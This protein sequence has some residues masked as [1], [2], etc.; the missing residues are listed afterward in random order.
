[1]ISNPADE[2]SG[3]STTAP[4]HISLATVPVVMNNVS[5]SGPPIATFDRIGVGKLTVS[6][7]SD[8]LENQIRHEKII[9]R[10]NIQ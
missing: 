3:S 9:P 10:K 8:V 1:M 5:E 6:N 4:V 2:G 7:N